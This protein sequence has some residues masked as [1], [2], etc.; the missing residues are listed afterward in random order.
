MIELEHSVNDFRSR[1][2]WSHVTNAVLLA[3]RHMK[4][5]NTSLSQLIVRNEQ[6]SI[7]SDENT[8]RIQTTQKHSKFEFAP[9]IRKCTAKA[10]RLIGIRK[11]NTKILHKCQ[12][13]S[14]CSLRKS[15]I[16]RRIMSWLNC[17]LAPIST[18]CTNFGCRISESLHAYDIG[19]L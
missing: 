4:N 14:I 2:R 16:K 13:K 10:I 6:Q 9:N 11:I 5:S 7:Y 19:H 17:Q 15:F 18:N 1:W 3:A 12:A 8:E